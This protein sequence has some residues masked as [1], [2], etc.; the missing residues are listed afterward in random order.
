MTFYDPNLEEGSAAVLGWDE[1]NALPENFWSDDLPKPLYWRMLVMPVQPR[2]VSKGGIVLP[3]SSQE[4]QKY[5]N[6]IGKVVGIGAL[7]G[8]DKRLLGEFNFPKVG[9]Y[10]I[11]GR[12][13]GQVLIYRGVRLLI[14][15]DDEILA[16][17]NNPEALKIQL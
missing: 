13:A 16:V 14:I 15:N 6:Y 12:Y 1:N 10:V 5:L 4:T 11:Y 8:T 9:D 17:A 3:A 7:A 2:T